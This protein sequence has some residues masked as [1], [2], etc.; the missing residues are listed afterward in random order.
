MRDGMRGVDGFSD[1]PI[2][3]TIKTTTTTTCDTT[4]IHRPVVER[5]AGRVTRS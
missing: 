2:G 5:L 3:S 4:L 1:A